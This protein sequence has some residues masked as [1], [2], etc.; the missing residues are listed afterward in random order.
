[1]IL[2]QVFVVR[3]GAIAELPAS[4]TLIAMKLFQESWAEKLESHFSRLI[5]FQ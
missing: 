5:V 2:S 1:M 3:N 4:R